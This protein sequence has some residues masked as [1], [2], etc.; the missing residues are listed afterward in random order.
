MLKLFLTMRRWS[1]AD[2]DL[3]ILAWLIRI[4]CQATTNQLVTLGKHT[5][6]LLGHSTIITPLILSKKLSFIINCNF[7]YLYLIV[8]KC[9]RFYHIFL[10]KFSR[11][12][13]LTSIVPHIT[14]LLLLLLLLLLLVL[15]LLLPLLSYS[16]IGYKLTLTTSLYTIPPCCYVSCQIMLSDLCYPYYA[17]LELL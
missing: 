5:S 12:P 4:W 7:C 15:P 16:S 10:K 1:S 14:F 13:S 11:Y 9:R 6:W 8:V 2:F 17:F 3:A